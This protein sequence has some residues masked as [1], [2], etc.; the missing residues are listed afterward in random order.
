MSAPRP[1]Q[2]PL[3]TALIAGGSVL[4]IATAWERIAGLHSLE[5]QEQL[6]EVVSRGQLGGLT[7]SSLATVLRVLCLIGG[8]AA[9]AA[10]VLAGQVPKRSR[11]ARIGLSVLAPFVLVGWFGTSGYFEPFVLVGIALLWLP[12]V[13]DWYAGREPAAR[14]RPVSTPVAAPPPPG[15]AAPPTALPPTWAPSAYPPLTRRPVSLVRA[16][17]TAW[18]CS[19]LTAIGMV[20]AMV[21][22]ARSGDAFIADV[23]DRSHAM[24]GSMA[25]SLTETQVRTEL[26]VVLALLL[27]WCLLAM[28]LA[29]LA[30]FGHGW[31]RIMLAVSAIGAGVCAL[32]G[33]I[34]FL[35]LLLVA[36]GCLVSTIQLLRSDAARWRG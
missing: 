15:P 18:V 29:A 11:S 16:C 6:A 10:A 36:V 7:V 23:I 13:A 30:W 33:A 4:V 32:I 27:L 19:G 22:L 21:W 24:W 12:P 1:A 28:A 31:A 26:Y 35:P 34:A 9:A 8:G 3:A 2:V 5:V 20:A 17:V 14:T 25:D